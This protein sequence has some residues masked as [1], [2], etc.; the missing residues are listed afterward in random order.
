MHPVRAGIGAV[1]GLALTA[2]V[3]ALFIPDHSALPYLLAPLGASA[4]LIFALPAAPLAQPRAV[5]G[6]N[7]ISALAG[8][9]AAMLIKEPMLAGPVGAGVAILLMQSLRVLHPPGG[10]IALVAVFGGEAVRA[11]GYSYALL[12]V[13]LNSLLLVGT[14]IVF[15]NVAGSPYPHRLPKPEEPKPQT[16]DDVATDRSGFTRQDVD[17]ALDRMEDRPDITV[18]DLDR[19]LRDVEAKAFARRTPVPLCLDIMSRDVVTCHADDRA[20]D[21]LAELD[22]RHVSALPVLDSHDRVVGLASRGVLAG[23]SGQTVRNVMQTGACIA[24][25]DSPAAALAPILSD[26]VHHQAVIIWNNGSL[27]GLVTQTDLLAALWRR[28]S[29]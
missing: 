23:A 29:D 2:F 14:G 5:I 19:L 20:E 27:A 28:S 6:G 26:G 7:V 9:T 21:A 10:A 22:R 4:V 13:G 1:A 8:V 12:P 25:A 24:A 11:A 17:A 15:N 3:T 16:Q 18:D